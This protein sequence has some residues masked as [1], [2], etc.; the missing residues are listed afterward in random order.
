MKART[1]F[2]RKELV[3]A[4]ACLCF[5]VF[6]LA[7]FDERGRAHAK[8]IVCLA[9]IRQLAHAWL[10]YAGDNDGQLVNG[11]RGYSN[12]VTSWGY[13]MHEPAW[14]DRWSASRE[15]AVRGI[16]D[17]ALWPYLRNEKIYRCPAA[18]RDEM[19]TYSIVLS[20]NAVCLPEV[21]GVPG[22]HVKRLTEIRHPQKRLVFVDQ[23]R[24]KPVAFSAYYG[25][26]LWWDGP[27]I[28][29]SDGA[30]VSFADGHSEH[31]QW[32]GIETVKNGW[33]NE[34]TWFE[35]WKPE[36][37]SGYQ[38]LYRMQKGCWGALGYAPSYA[39]QF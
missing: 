37:E 31:W 26:E 2:G 23:G 36:T 39:P 38:D 28:R 4:L 1:A 34:E 16:R 21:Q 30:T 18:R 32:K 24:I 27:P 11:A 15:E 22:A 7:A 9:N 8:K 6:N 20:M 3:V 35:K 14:V 33:R 19:L 17:G 13:H 25:Q 5:L 10:L 12:F 29:H